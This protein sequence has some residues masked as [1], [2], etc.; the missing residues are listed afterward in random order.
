[1]AIDID[2]IVGAGGELEPQ[3]L[4]SAYRQGVFPWPMDGLEVI[5]WFC[6]RQRAILDFKLVH[7]PRSLRR[8]LRQTEFTCTVDTQFDRV[9]E[10]CGEVPRPGQEGTWITPE[11]LAAYK[12]LHRMGYAHSVEVWSGLNADRRLVGGIYGVC[13]D[14]VFSAESM[15]HL[16]PNASKIALF[17]LMS[18]LE[19]GGLDWMDIQVM[20]P[21]MK[22]LGAINITRRKFLDKL[23][24]TQ[25]KQL[26]PF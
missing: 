14:G 10:L 17:H 11:L 3:V 13:V 15:F 21:H 8:T 22:A 7:V 18:V 19:K 25:A 12:E 5:P 1:M 23:A 6:P 26:K 24:R 4:I 9:I 16:E 2:D 20:T